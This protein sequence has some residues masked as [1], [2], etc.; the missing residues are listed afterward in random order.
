MKLNSNANVT[1]KSKQDKSLML[2]LSSKLP[3][4]LVTQHH[5]SKANAEA[6]FKFIYKDVVAN[7]QEN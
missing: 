7:G 1:K 4:A 5:M 6:V 2:A 3:I